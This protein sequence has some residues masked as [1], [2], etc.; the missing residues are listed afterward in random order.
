MT[1]HPADAVL[2]ALHDAEARP[3]VVA[4]REHVEWC[5]ECRTR[6]DL[7]RAHT[8]HLREALDAIPV[9]PFDPTALRRRLD[10][11]RLAR[12]IVPLWRRPAMQIVAAV[13]A[14]SA[15]A[16][17]VRPLRTLID[18]PRPSRERV[19][20]PVVA[21]PTRQDGSGSTVSFLP[22]GDTLTLRFDSSQSEGVLVIERTMAPEISAQVT[23]GA[24]SVG[25]AMVVLPG[26]LRL[27][28]SI[29]SRAS[30]R[31]LVPGA[32]ERVRVFVAGRALV[33]GLP[34]HAPISLVRRVEP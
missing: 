15:A 6:L 32:I 9:P 8:R 2:L 28:N 16:A 26:E 29:A 5:N 19:V 33:D 14:V 17:V 27:R 3:D 12:R 24:D 10:E 7:V 25:D 18:H 30:Y 23:S 11:Q 34:P 13:V 4:A 20:A 31:V 21:A 1:S 22:T